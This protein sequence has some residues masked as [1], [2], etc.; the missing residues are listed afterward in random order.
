MIGTGVH[1]LGLLGGFLNQSGKYDI[2]LHTAS[3]EYMTEYIMGP[4]KS[5]AA[6]KHAEDRR[7]EHL[8]Q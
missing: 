6:H 4:I 2:G 7:I 1:R 3:E 8:A 5:N